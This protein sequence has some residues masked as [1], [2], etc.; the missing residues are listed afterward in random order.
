MRIG[1]IKQ[2][3]TV[4]EDAEKGNYNEIVKYLKSRTSVE[5]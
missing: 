5:Q 1:I 2:K 4:E 3:I